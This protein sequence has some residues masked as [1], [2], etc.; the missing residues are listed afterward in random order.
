M[1]NTA[2][3]ADLLNALK[4]EKPARSAWERRV[5]ATAYEIVEA[6]DYIDQL[7]ISSR[8]ALEGALLNGARDW[9][10]Y[11]WG[12]CSLCYNVEI[13]E[14]YMT[15]SEFK[16]YMAPGH[17]A[18]EGFGGEQLLDLQ[19]RALRAA[20]IHAYRAALRLA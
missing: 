17:D 7:D 2:K 8:A 15:P 12:G 3:R 14:R 20:F 6:I 9:S 19:A 16:R 1:K 5:Q 13:A 10:Q 4:N 11:S 18:S